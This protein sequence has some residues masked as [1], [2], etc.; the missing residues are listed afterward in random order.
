[1]VADL[2]KY[3]RSFSKKFFEQDKLWG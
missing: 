1:M 2:L 3:R